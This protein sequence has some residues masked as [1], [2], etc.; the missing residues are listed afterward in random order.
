MEVKLIL[1]HSKYGRSQTTHLK[2]ATMFIRHWLKTS[3]VC[4]KA[5]MF[6]K[7]CQLSF[8]TEQELTKPQL[9][10]LAQSL[11]NHCQTNVRLPMLFNNGIKLQMH[12]RAA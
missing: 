10:Y 5:D 3:I 6:N 1:E 8:S 2:L 7:E 12:Y 11:A 4:I 9:A